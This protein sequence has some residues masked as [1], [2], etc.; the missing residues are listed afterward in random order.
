MASVCFL[1]TEK[2]KNKATY[3]DYVLTSNM[4]WE[5]K[6]NLGTTSNSNSLFY[7]NTDGFHIIGKL[8]KN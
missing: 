3:F 1:N 8:V 5:K 2:G 4:N 6:N 7:I